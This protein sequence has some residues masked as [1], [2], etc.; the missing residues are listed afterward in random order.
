MVNPMKLKLV[1]RTWFAASLL[2]VSVVLFGCT[3]Q[4]TPPVPTVDENAIVAAA[5]ETLAAQMTSEAINNPSPTPLPT[6][7]PV[8]SATPLPPTESPAATLAPTQAPTQAA[9]LSA[10]FVYVVTFPE[11]KRIYVPNEEYGVALGFE[12]TGTI[13]WNSGYYVK[14]VDYKGEVTIQ[15]QLAVDKSAKPGERIEFD[16]WAFGSETLGQ[17]TFVYQLYTETGIAVPGGVGVY[18]YTSE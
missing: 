8:P 6:S 14:L 13:V 3:P 15:T 9:A 1:N 10:Q 17:H 12:N 2:I 5:V 18:T 11:N 4:A 16:L 7:T